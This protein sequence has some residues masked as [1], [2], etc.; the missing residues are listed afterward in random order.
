MEQNLEL[1]HT[2]DLQ[3]TREDIHYVLTPI[4]GMCLLCKSLGLFPLYFFAFRL[5]FL[6][7]VFWLG[8][9]A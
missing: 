3:L 2:F 6:G 8:F 9:F 5:F 4:Y 7:F 1:V